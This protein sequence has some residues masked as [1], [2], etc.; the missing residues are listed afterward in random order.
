MKILYFGVYKPSYPRNK[1]IID[2]LRQNGADVTECQTYPGFGWQVRL[3][4]KYF[5]IVRH[6][7]SN[8]MIVGFPGQEVMFLAKIIYFKPIVFDVFTSHYMGYILDRQYFSKKS[9][10]T[11]YYRFLDRWSCKLADS[12][13]L[14]TQAHINFFTREFNLN[15]SKFTRIWL[16]AN[17]E[18]HKPKILDR[19]DSTFYILFWGSFIPL[20]G[21]DV[22][23]KA[24]E[25]LKNEKIEFNLIG[26]GQMF[27]EIKKMAQDK[28]LTKINFLGKVSDKVLVEYI[29]TTDLCLGVFSGGEKADITIQNKIFESL[30]SKKPMI[31]VKTTALRE[32]LNDGQGLM[33]CEKNNPQDLANKIMILKNNPALRQKIA[34]EGYSL[35]NDRLTP[36]KIGQDLLKVLWTIKK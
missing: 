21:V 33:L 18:L 22:I 4:I 8:I 3:L 19:D 27:N 34:E 24:A 32:L 5:S 14:D 25:L 23:I 7:N 13:F 17:P 2:G 12:I 26:K 11:L 29:T 10:R 36:K 20:Q 15:P 31:T 6:F 9:L 35:F 16:G 1:I 28:E 30:A